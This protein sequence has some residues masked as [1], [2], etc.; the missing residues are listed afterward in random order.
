MPAISILTLCNTKI[1]LQLITFCITKT[2][3]VD[4]KKMGRPKVS[5]K[6]AKRN[7][8]TLRLK[9]KEIKQIQKLA[10]KENLTVSEWS[11]NALQNALRAVK[12][13]T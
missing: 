1:S 9:D 8:F 3:N 4:K 2:M 5:K 11:R 10:R 7:I 13:N 12:C 6:E